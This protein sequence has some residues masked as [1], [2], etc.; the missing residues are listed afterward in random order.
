[1]DNEII[2]QGKRYS[3]RFSI[4]EK[5]SERQVYIDGEYAARWETV[6]DS[7]FQGRG[8]IKDFQTGKRER[9]QFLAK[10]NSQKAIIPYLT[11][12]EIK[13][14]SKVDFALDLL[15]K[16]ARESHEIY[17]MVNLETAVRLVD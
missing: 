3:G 1:M 11:E 12:K 4:E 14:K 5:T 6:K 10:E 13:D 8:T 9:F 7:W 16:Q 2:I 15:Y 17:P